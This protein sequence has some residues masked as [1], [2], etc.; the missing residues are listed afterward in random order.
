MKNIG[1]AIFLASAFGISGLA[2]AQMSPNFMVANQ[3]C[4]EGML[5]E[6]N[7]G[8]VSFV[9]GPSGVQATVNTVQ[10]AGASPFFKTFRVTDGA[11]GVQ[12]VVGGLPQIGFKALHGYTNLSAAIDFYWNTFT[13]MGYAATM[14]TFGTDTSTYTFDNGVSTYEAVFTM[15]GDDISVTFTPIPTLVA[16]R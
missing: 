7:S 10:T 3:H 13:G 16:G 2:A 5:A 8:Y 9:V 14:G 6:H 11:A 12:H 15:E 4:S 1:V